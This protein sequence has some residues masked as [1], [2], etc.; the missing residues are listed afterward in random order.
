MLKVTH[1]LITSQQI[2]VH[3]SKYDQQEYNLSLL[4]RSCYVT[5]A[6]LNGLNSP[7]PC[8]YAAAMS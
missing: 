1:E 8:R 5:P 7:A 3:P 6:L 2:V 4:H